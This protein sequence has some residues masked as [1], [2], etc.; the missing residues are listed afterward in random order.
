MH[1]AISTVRAV[2]VTGVVGGLPGPPIAADVGWRGGGLVGWSECGWGGAGFGVVVVV[3]GW[4]VLGL[5]GTERRY[6][7]VVGVVCTGGGLSGL[8]SGW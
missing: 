6:R 3:L 4:P 8:V 5:S 7:V 2:R 1:R